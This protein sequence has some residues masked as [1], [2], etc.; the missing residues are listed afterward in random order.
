MYATKHWP[1]C[2]GYPVFGVSAVL[3]FQLSGQ[4]PNVVPGMGFMV[5][6]VIYGIG[7]ALLGGWLAARIARRREQ[8]HAGIVAGII[9]LLALVSMAVNRASPWSEI[10]VVVCMAPAAALGGNCG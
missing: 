2:F 10:A 8:L 9:G 7:F 1:S 5:F 4:D 6:S 3:L